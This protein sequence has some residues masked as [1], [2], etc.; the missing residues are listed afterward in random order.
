MNDNEIDTT[1]LSHSLKRVMDKY[2]RKFRKH[3]ICSKC[4][5]EME[6]MILKDGQGLMIYGLCKKDK[7]ILILDYIHKDLN[8][9]SVLEESNTA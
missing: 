7:E 3:A 5:D 6:L 4:K 8:F 2:E 1:L 9:G